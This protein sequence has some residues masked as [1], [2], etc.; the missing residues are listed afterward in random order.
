MREYDFFSGL[1]LNNCD[2]GRQVDPCAV[3][4]GVPKPPSATRHL[5][6]RRI[7]FRLSLLIISQRS[8]EI[9]YICANCETFSPSFIL[10]VLLNRCVYSLF[11][12]SSQQEQAMVQAASDAY[13]PSRSQRALL[14]ET[15]EYNSVIIN[16]IYIASLG[17]RKA[18][19]Q[20]LANSACWKQLF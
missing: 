6:D 9:T 11:L 2:C 5:S 3:W 17:E 19:V 10:R 8:P 15:E 20:I 16:S 1:L 4:G 14:S 7:Y 13:V 18:W 12:M